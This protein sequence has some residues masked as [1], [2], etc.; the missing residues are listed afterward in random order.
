MVLRLWAALLRHARRPRRRRHRLHQDEHGDD[1]RRGDG[2]LAPLPPRRRRSRSPCR[3]CVPAPRFSNGLGRSSTF[4]SQETTTGRSSWTWTAP[5]VYWQY[6]GFVEV[7]WRLTVSE[8]PST[9]TFGDVP[10][11]HP[12][13]QFIEALAKS[14]ITGGCGSGTNFCPD[15]PL[16]RGQMATFLAKALGA[17]LTGRTERAVG[18]RRYSAL[19]R[20]GRASRPAGRNPMI[21]KREWGILSIAFWAAAAAA[22]GAS[23]RSSTAPST[24]RRVRDAGRD[25]HDR[26][27]RTV[28]VQ[29]RELL[30][31]RHLL[32]Y[33]C[34]DSDYCP[35]GMHYYA[36][37]VLPA[38]R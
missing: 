5:S 11:S 28:P 33:C 32:S 27:G 30:R 12:Y 1:R 15:A 6:F 16:T 7:W 25:D 37:V 31:R 23:D 21:R 8:P 34:P 29:L 9:P 17:S 22:A 2:L 19:C 4:R 18:L 26:L 14:G 36:P 13:Y 3:C 35:S 20:T 10:T 38:G 24:R